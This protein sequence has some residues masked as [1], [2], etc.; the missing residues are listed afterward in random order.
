MGL[1][2]GGAACGQK[3]GAGHSVQVKGSDTM[4]N[5][6]QA[7]GEEYNRIRPDIAIVVSGGGSGTGIAAIINGTTDIATASREIKEQEKAD[8]KKNSS[9]DVVEHVVAYDALAVYIHKDNPLTKLTKAELACIY[10]EGGTCDKW[11][12][13]GIDVPG[14]AGQEIIRVSRQSNSGT[15]AF[16][17]EWTIGEKQDFKLGSRDMQ[18][19]KDVV[20]LVEQT[21]CAIGYSGLGYKTASVKTACV[22]SNDTDPCVE[23]TIEGAISGK[24]PLSRALY[25]YT[26]GEPSGEVKA[27]IDW[28]R[29]DAGQVLVEQAG[30]APLTKEK[31]TVAGK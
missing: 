17:R 2:A 18:G 3:Q 16:F 8:A 5:I 31:R 11:S 10:G 26:L 21:P 29:S 28:V 9:K 23:P 27:Y 7:W 20:D 15:Y 22:A 19:S 25:M 6:A 1:W 14:C 30:F 12:D 24:Y 13:V 4:V